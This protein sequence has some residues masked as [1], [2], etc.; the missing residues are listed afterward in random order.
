MQDALLRRIIGAMNAAN[1]SVSRSQ[2]LPF[3]PTWT[4]Q[5]QCKTTPNRNRV[6]NEKTA[7]RA[8]FKGAEIGDEPDPRLENTIY[9]GNMRVPTGRVQHQSDTR[10]VMIAR[11]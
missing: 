5:T 10:G 3:A 6:T 8:V 11:L 4:A 9:L 7:T 1:A 2:V